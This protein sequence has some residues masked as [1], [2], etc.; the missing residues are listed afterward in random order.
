MTITTD[1]SDYES[2]SDSSD[3]ITKR[4]FEKEESIPAKTIA[5]CRE[6]EGIVGEGDNAH[7]GTGKGH[8][9]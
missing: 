8:P 2:H 6:V 9:D 4:C 3:K 5:H 1:D 7:S